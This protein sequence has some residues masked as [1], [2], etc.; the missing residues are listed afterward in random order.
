MV[1]WAE[2]PAPPASKAFEMSKLR[3]NFRRSPIKLH[4]KPVRL[5]G[6]RSKEKMTGLNERRPPGKLPSLPQL[7]RFHAEIRM[8]QKMRI[9]VGFE[10]HTGKIP[11]PSFAAAAL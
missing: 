7:F 1:R 11:R 2:D 10:T 6:V 4:L 3:S 8:H 9:P 5:Y